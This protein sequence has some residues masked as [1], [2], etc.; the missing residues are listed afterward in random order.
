VIA[1]V[2]VICIV[3]FVI[4]YVLVGYVRQVAL[5]RNVVDI[6]NERSSHT[7][8]TPRGGGIAIVISFLIAVSGLTA[9]HLL[10][11]K[12][13]LVV[14]ISSCVVA[15]VGLMDD[16]RPLRASMRL[17]AHVVAAVFV[18]SVLGGIPATELV[19]WGLRGFWL[20]S[21]FSVLVLVWATNLFNF[22]DGIDGIAGSESFYM[23]AAGGWLNWL[24]GGDPGITAAF[25]SLS[26]AS[27]GFLP[28]NWPPASVFLGDVGSG[29]L[30]FIVSAL[31]MIA[32]VI[33]KVPIEVLPILGGVFLVDATMTLLR[34]IFRGDRW[35]EPHRAHAY[36]VL[37][38][39]LGGHRPVTLIV[40]FVNVLWLLP[41][42]Y[43]TNR[44]PGNSRLYLIAALLPL[45]IVWI[46]VGAGKREQCPGAGKELQ[47]R[48]R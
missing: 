5:D 48:R 18:V 21:G 10:T 47:D 25:L 9:I 1:E 38:R 23:S 14:V 46:M 12:I 34:R 3:A 24:N 43:A 6:P 28:W 33:G 30:G 29:F 37:A 8:P 41:W 13:W 27:L 32:C 19:K 39:R 20:G 36:Q 15:G 2:A 35:F 26:V 31:L 42:A 45:V 4:S 16:R 7:V 22:M 11:L 40:F 17:A 44:F